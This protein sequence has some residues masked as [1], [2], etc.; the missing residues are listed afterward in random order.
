[1]S[2]LLTN[3]SHG[4][5]ITIKIAVEWMRIRLEF[6]ISVFEHVDGACTFLEVSGNDK[7][8]LMVQKF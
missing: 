2:L 6:F 5:K 8:Q 1:M 7:S 3:P 4:H